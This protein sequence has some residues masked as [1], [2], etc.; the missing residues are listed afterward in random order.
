MERFFLVYKTVNKIKGEYYIGVHVTDN[1]DDGYLGSGKRL[2]YSLEKHGR[3]IFE[4][5]IL[6]V[7]DNS[8]DMFN[9]EAELVNEKT[10][11]DPLCLNLK[12]GGYGG[13]CLKDAS[14]LW[15]S[16]FQKKR[17]PFNKKEWKEQNASKIKEWSTKGLSNG[18]KKLDKMRAEGWISPG[19]AGK[20]HTTDFKQHM[21]TIMSEA[22]SGEKNSQ[23]G[24]RWIHSFVEKRN[25]KVTSDEL[26]QWLD[27]GWIIGRKMKFD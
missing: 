4:R 26:Q 11:L 7:F 6:D 2:R 27:K 18:R 9:K 21:S 23:Y 15:S 1:I 19:F 12:V 14:I 8:N 24:R 20:R 16:D 3:E 17:S 5:E 10:L 22:Q 13:W 25:T